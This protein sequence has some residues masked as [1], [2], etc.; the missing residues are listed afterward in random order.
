MNY[1]WVRVIAVPIVGLALFACAP[2]APKGDTGGGGVPTHPTPGGGGCGPGR[3]GCSCSAEGATA[4]C[5]DQVSR[6]GDY[7]TCS[8]GT[9]TCHGGTWGPCIGNTLVTRSLA[10]ATL[11]SGGVRPLSFTQGCN[12][13]CDPNQCF[14]TTS[15]GNDVDASLTTLAD[16]SL[17]VFGDAAVTLPPDQPCQGMQCQIELGCPA[18]SST[19]L[20]GVVRDPAGVNPVYNATV[21]V[22]MLNGPLPAFPSGATCDACSEMQ[23]VQAVAVTQTA[24]D[25]SFTLPLVPSTDV[26]PGH[27]IPLVVQLGKWR[28]QTMLHVVPSCQTTTVAANDSRLPRNRQDGFNNVADLPRLAIVSGKQDPME[29]LLLRIGIDPAEFEI[30]SA[31]GPGHVDFFF[32][33]GLNLAAGAPPGTQLYGQAGALMPYDVTLLPCQGQNVDL[34]ANLYSGNIDSYLAAGGRAFMTHASEQ[35]LVNDPVYSGVASWGPLDAGLVSSASATIDPTP[36]NGVAFSQWLASVGASTAPGVM[37]ITAAYKNIAG[38]NAPATESM[39]AADAAPPEP[40]SFSFDTPLGATPDAGPDA[41]GACGRVVYSDFHVS[42]ADLVTSGNCLTNNDCGFGATC[43]GATGVLGTCQAKSCARSSDCVDPTYSC[44]GA[45]GGTCVQFIPCQDNTDCTSANCQGVTCVPAPN[46]RCFGDLDCQ[47][48]E[49]CMGN[50]QGVCQKNCNSDTDCTQGQLCAGNTGGA[51]GTCTGCLVAA[52]CPSGTCNGAGQPGKCSV[53]GDT[54]PLMCR[55]GALTP[56]EDALEFM[57]LDLTSCQATP[58]ALIE[59]FSPATFIEDF[60]SPCPPSTRVIWRE[61]DWQAV[62]PMTASIVFSAQT[63]ASPLDGGA[64]A[65]AGVPRV[66]VATAT[67]STTLPGTDFQFLDTGGTGVFN[68]AMPPVTSSDHL[69]LTITM[70]PTSDHSRPPTLLDW[71]VKADCVASE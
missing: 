48:H 33:N 14:I 22:P 25:G 20:T 54:F 15:N 56:Q 38:V 19:T 47:D 17:A 1:P 41:G 45:L 50:T 40:L 35:W 21:Y 32:G 59:T 12:D 53:S 42:S 29:C 61:L 26:A 30:P 64:V 46:F 51:T 69:R 68:T 24:P 5:G 65:W 10:G 63:V 43:N 70:S 6:S 31:T 39:Q 49:H 16:A 34:Q 71:S 58:T 67:Q 9:S 2:S 60:T 44:Q 27:D 7:V 13:A 11:G 18:A 66:T 36:P 8:M 55:Q 62:I 52:N 37:P 57:L 3:A 4:A 23:Q 28:R